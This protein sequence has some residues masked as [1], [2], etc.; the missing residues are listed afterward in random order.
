[1][2]VDKEELVQRAKLAEQAERYDD[3][4][5]AMKAVTE[6]GVELSN[7]ERNL[8]SVAYK[9]VVGARRSSWRVISSIEQKTEGSERKQQMAKEYRE[10]VEKELR[11]I[12]YDVLVS[13]SSIDIIFFYFSI[14]LKMSQL[15]L[16]TYYYN[17]IYMV[18]DDLTDCISDYIYFCT[19][20]TYVHNIKRENE[21]IF[22]KN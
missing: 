20:N 9:N 3:M 15:H 14:S 21:L 12:C 22:K 7:E 16:L 17:K 13:I 19:R 1:M 11:E 2:S 10:K 18:T 6:T 4:A 5:S 8:L